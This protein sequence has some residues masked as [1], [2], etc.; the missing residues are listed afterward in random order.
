MNSHE[1]AEKTA[2]LAS[3]LNNLA[4]YHTGKDSRDLLQ[5]QA[6]LA[7]L[8]S[9]AIIEDLNAEHEAYQAALSGLEVAIKYIGNADQQIEGVAEAIRLA[10]K[11]A[12]MV[13]TALKVAAM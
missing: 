13:E 6:R 7:D 2:G 11:A 9:A 10:A 8:A 3:R 4:V 5:E 1:L 12:A